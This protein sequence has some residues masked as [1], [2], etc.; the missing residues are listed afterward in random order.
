FPEAR[1]ELLPPPGPDG[2]VVVEPN[3]ETGRRPYFLYAGRI[4]AIKGVDRLV[5]AFP[6]VRGADLLVAGDGSGYDELRRSAEGSNAVRLV[7]RLTH[8]EILG[9]CRQ[10]RA[11]VVPSAGYETFGG[12]AVEA[13]A[14][15]TPVVVHD[16]GPL[17]ELVESG[18]GR[19][20]VDDD[21]LVSLLQQL[22]DDPAEARRI[23]QEAR[24]IAAERFGTN[25]F[26]R[27]YLDI[28]SDLARAAGR[29]ELGGR[30]AAAAAVAS[31]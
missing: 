13:M 14:L 4:E 24:S 6:R 1:V 27:R 30:A 16:L 10:A 12:V 21:Q 31:V 2:D 9:L 28:V 11:V 29:E 22:V 18:G 25:L 3:L 7:G 19:T 8:P 23:G 5:Q 20:Y 15:G 17:P 26:F